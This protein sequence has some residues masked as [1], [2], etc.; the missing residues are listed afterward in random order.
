MQHSMFNAAQATRPA[1]AGGLRGQ[2]RDAIS[3]DVV[4]FLATVPRIPRAAAPTF[5]YPHWIC[6]NVASCA[7]FGEVQQARIAHPGSQPLIL[8][9][10]LDLQPKA[11][12]T[13]YFLF[14]DK[15]RAELVAKNPGA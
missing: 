14:Q 4:I 6:E 8:V 3:V 2:F 7:T 11:P 12:Q 1:A 9:F 13:A 15:A 10:H 5:R